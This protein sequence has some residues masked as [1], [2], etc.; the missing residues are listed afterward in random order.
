MQNL[1]RHAHLHVAALGA[2]G[3]VTCRTVLGGAAKVKDRRVVPVI[4]GGV[5]H[6]QQ[7][8]DL[9]EG[10]LLKEHQLQAAVP[11]HLKQRPYGD[12]RTDAG[13][14]DGPSTAC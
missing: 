12:P 9:D 14:G 11:M 7:R 6:K 5:K 4:V 10:A 1:C 2:G 3:Q 13:S 8:N